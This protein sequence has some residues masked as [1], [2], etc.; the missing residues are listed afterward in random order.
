MFHFQIDIS[1]EALTQL[2]KEYDFVSNKTSS[3]HIASENLIQEQRQLNDIS[4]DIR[5]RLKHF[6]QAEHLSQRLQNPTFTPASDQFVDIINNIDECM[7]YLKQHPKFKDTSTYSVKY[8]QCLLKAIQM[9][10]NY[11][12]Q[13]LTAATEQVLQPKSNSNKDAV[14][15]SDKSSEAAFALYYGKFQA[16]SMKIRKIIKLVEERYQKNAEYE[17]LL[18]ELH[19]FYLSQR[20]LIMSSGVD[21]AIKDLCVKHKGDHCAL[22][23]SSCTFLVHICQDEHR[24][25]YQ[26]FNIQSS[27]LT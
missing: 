6:T 26:F 20:A 27:Q 11:V 19:Q 2:T 16:S 1:L 12:I 4:D 21:N 17:N 5:H 23:R 9:M 7:D 8:K 10:K 25:F 15:I 24:L 13:V 14:K 18:S 3:L 22:T